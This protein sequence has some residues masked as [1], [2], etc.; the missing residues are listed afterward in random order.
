[1]EQPAEEMFD[2]CHGHLL[3]QLF[4]RTND[5]S[6]RPRFQRVGFFVV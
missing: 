5:P 1:V 2:E 6:P 4:S 3:L